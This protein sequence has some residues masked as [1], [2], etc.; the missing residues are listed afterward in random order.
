MKVFFTCLLLSTCL[1]IKGQVESEV[2]AAKYRELMIPTM[3]KMKTDNF[4][5]DIHYTIKMLSNPDQ[6]VDAYS[7]NYVFANDNFFMSQSSGFVCQD[8]RLN[9]LVDTVDRVTYLRNTFSRE[10]LDFPAVIEDFYTSVKKFEVTNLDKKNI[11]TVYFKET[12]LIKWC[13]L[14]FDESGLLYL[15]EYETVN[16]DVDLEGI[17]LSVKYMY[18]E[19]DSNLTDH[20]AVSDILEMKS[21]KAEL[22]RGYK[23]YQIIDLRY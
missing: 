11:L 22:K 5:L 18:T 10:K 21:N 4:C 6:V 20:I 14:F 16:S 19:C 13:K 23:G 3:S 7:T 15:S 1:L 17:S 8:Q 12:E 9:L 2:F